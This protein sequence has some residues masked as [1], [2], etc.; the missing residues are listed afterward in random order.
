MKILLYLFF[1][2]ISLIV[3]GQ[4]KFNYQTDF[5]KIKAQNLDK[6]NKLYFDN[7]LERFEAN[8][9]TLSNFEVLSLLIGFTN[10][11]EYRPYE[12]IK[13]EDE[14][15]DLNGKGKFKEALE[16]G[17]IFIKTHPF[18]LKVL[19]EIKFSYNKLNNQKEAYNFEFKAEKIIQAMFYSGK[20]KTIETPTFALGPADGQVYLRK[21]GAGIGT[22]GSGFDS[23]GNFLDILEA[24]FKDGTSTNIYFI[25][26]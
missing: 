18:S 14:V 9:T 6:N 25:I 11:N 8:D 26:L 3:I 21:L 24:K 15:Y 17:L 7:Q 13:I 16:K 2:F 1:C 23:N 10:K 19:F 12:D 20:G 22:M 4:E 5:K